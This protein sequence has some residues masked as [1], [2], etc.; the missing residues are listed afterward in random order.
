MRIGLLILG[1]LAVVSA[2]FAAP[3]LCYVGNGGHL[4]LHKMD[5]GGGLPSELGDLSKLLGVK[6]GGD[7]RITPEDLAGGVCRMPQ[8]LDHDRIIFIYD[9]KPDAMPPKTKVGIL[10]L[11]TKSIQWVS[12]LGGSACIGFDKASKTVDFM[13]MT[14]KNP[15]S[16]SGE[17]YLGN[18]VLATGKGKS[19]FA[20]KSW[21]YM[22]PKPIYRW[23]DSTLRLLAVGTSDVSDQVGVYS[24]A[25]KKFVPVK[26]LEDK[27]K[28]SNIGGWATMAM[29]PGPGGVFAMSVL[30]SDNGQMSCTLARI[31]K[32]SGAVTKLHSSSAM[33]R[34]PAF[35]ADGAWI[36]WCEDNLQE[37]S[38]TVWV[39]PISDPSPQKIAGGWDP[40]WRP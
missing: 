10:N 21:G 11:T 33:V 31:E 30:S 18:Y 8:W 37:A 39:S 34:S 6:P 7:K 25:K 16:E 13:K 38:K 23:P 26:W 17:V 22:T 35:S 12:S 19:A 4:Y 15:D 27:W 1:V 2:G 40:A 14:K 24:P 36:A 28:A 29:S 5:A 9:L 20:Y 32:S 3:E